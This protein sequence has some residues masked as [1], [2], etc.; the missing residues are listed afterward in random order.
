MSKSIIFLVKSFLGKFYRNLAIFFWSHCSLLLNI[1]YH[2]IEHI[3]EWV[4]NGIM[5]ESVLVSANEPR[6]DRE[7]PSTVLPIGQN[8]TVIFNSSC[9]NYCFCSNYVGKK[10]QCDQIWRF[11]ATITNFGNLKRVPL[12]LGKILN[13]LWQILRK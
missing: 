4:T 3:V 9:H 1:D 10:Q 11:F 7:M 8:W 5:C 2:I 13:L 12:V 6:T